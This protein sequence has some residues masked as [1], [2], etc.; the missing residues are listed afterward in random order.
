[1]SDIN[2]NIPTKWR[3]ARRD[4]T[5]QFTVFLSRCAVNIAPKRFTVSVH[6]PTAD[7]AVYQF[8]CSRHPTTSQTMSVYNLKHPQCHAD[9]HRTHE[10][11]DSAHVPL[12]TDLYVWGNCFM[13]QL[14]LVVCCSAGKL[15]DLGSIH[16][17]SP[18][19]S[20]KLWF[21]PM[22]TVLWLCPHG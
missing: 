8:H 3:W 9:L 20:K 11:W 19:S 2:R 15:M 1:M 18:F 6:Y 7:E 21:M 12:I 22:D 17:G 4:L 13:S 10:E 14:G 5:K 16:S